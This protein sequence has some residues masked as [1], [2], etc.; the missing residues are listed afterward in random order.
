[1]FNNNKTPAM[2]RDIFRYK[3]CNAPARIRTHD[4]VTGRQTLPTVPRWLVYRFT[5]WSK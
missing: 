5:K 4:L 3:K 2:H 1:M